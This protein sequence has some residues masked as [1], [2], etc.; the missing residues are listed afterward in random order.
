M[1]KGQ[2]ISSAPTINYYHSIRVGLEILTSSTPTNN[3][4]HGLRKRLETL[5]SS[6]STNNYCRNLRKGLKIQLVS[7][8]FTSFVSGSDIPD[9]TPSSIELAKTDYALWRGYYRYSGIK[10]SILAA[11]SL[12]K[13]T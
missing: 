6:T 4:Y 12:Y 1:S 7:T 8:T 10:D 9:V 3:H 5:I 2:I 13:Y 11:H